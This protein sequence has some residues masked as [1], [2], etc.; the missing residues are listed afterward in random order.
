MSIP[1]KTIKQVSIKN[2]N[3]RA[4]LFIDASDN[5][6]K[7]KIND[8]FYSFSLTGNDDPSVNPDEPS[9]T[10][11]PDLIASGFSETDYSYNS[12]IPTNKFNGTWVY[13][14]QD[15]G[16]DVWVHESGEYKLCLPNYSGL[17]G[18]P[19]WQ[20]FLTEDNPDTGNAG[21]FWEMDPNHG[22]AYSSPVEVKQWNS[23]LANLTGK[24]EYKG[25]ID[26]P[27][28]N[29]YV[30][31]CTSCGDGSVIG[32]YRVIT[33]TEYDTIFPDSSNVNWRTSTDT[34][35]YTY[36]MNENNGILIEAIDSYDESYGNLH[37]YKVMDAQMGTWL[38]VIPYDNALHGF[39]LEGYVPDLWMIENGAEPAPT[40]I[41]LFF[42][43]FICCQE[44]RQKTARQTTDIKRHIFSRIITI[45]N[46]KG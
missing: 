21:E 18:Y 17:N 12:L 22:S 43:L 20:V 6:L 3:N 14:Q 32:K 31:E 2:T 10:G 5:I 46:M 30:Y 36:Y 27:V 16:E 34:I 28:T 42:S 38:Y 4:Y 9:T 24:F 11:K 39:A 15:N 45:H 26:T 25:N 41:K 29:A 7:M 40:F 13:S 19:V 33:K 1:I 44:A 37:E 8:K 35:T 23:Q